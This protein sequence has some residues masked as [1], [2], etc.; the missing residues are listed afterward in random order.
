[1]RIWMV[2]LFSCFGLLVQAQ[3]V[4]VAVS[5]MMQKN[6]VAAD[7]VSIWVQAIEAEQPLVE[8]NSTVPRHPASVAKVLT[9]AAG[10]LRLGADYRWETRFLVDTLPDANGVVEGNLYIVGGAD[11][12][13]VEEQLLLMLQG[14]Q[15]AGVRHI[16]GDI[17][18]DDSFYHLKPEERDASSFDG[19]PWAAYNAVPNPLMVNF[20]TVKMHVAPQAGAKP[21]LALVPEIVN[22]KID[23][24]LQVRKGQ[25]SGDGFTPSAVLERDDKGYAVM[26]VAGTYATGC[27]EQDV[28]LVLGEASEQFYYLFRDLWYRLGGSFDGAGKMA[29]TPSTAK[30]VYSGYSE[31]LAIQIQRMNQESNNVMTRQLMLTLGAQTYELPGTVEKGRNAVL[32]TL[33]AFGIHTDGMV[34]DNGAGLSRQTRVTAQ[35]LAS[36]LRNIYLSDQGET[37]LR[38]LAVAGE[39]GTLRK[40][41]R[42]EVLAGR[43]LGKT[44]TIDSVRSFAGFVRAESGRNYVVVIIGNGQSAVRSRAMQDDLFRWIYKQ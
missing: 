10:L 21:R 22:W 33:E 25:C 37:F 14:L 3:Q 7:D 42:G 35:Q 23:N 27:G 31:P 17:V 12:F 15:Q 36:L 4:P 6:K 28:Q 11:P 19:K 32:M 39:S 24:Q 8:L 44:G 40:R 13:L 20:R 29:K 5:D 26:H 9:T 34:I 38:S 43:V 30:L 2:L 16:T 1:M 41:Y 18:L